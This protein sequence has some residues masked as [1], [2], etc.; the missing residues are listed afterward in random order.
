MKSVT[1]PRVHE[2]LQ[3]VIGGRGAISYLTKEEVERFFCAIPATKIRDRL[4]F[5]LIYRHG[6]RRREAALICI[7]NILPDGKIWIPRVKGGVPGSYSVHP[8]TRT[9]LNA[10]LSERRFDGCRYLLRGIRHRPTPLSG[11]LIYLLFRR[12]AT[13]AGIAEERRHVQW[14][15]YSCS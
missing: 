15:R 13:S 8:A 4:M 2:A 6:L 5:D 11:T 14:L 10:Y 3:S 9:L 7:E 1:L 12:Y